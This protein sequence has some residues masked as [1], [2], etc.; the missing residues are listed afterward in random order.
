MDASWSPAAVSTLQRVE[1][2]AALAIKEPVGLLAE[3]KHSP[4]LSCVD[5]NV[6]VVPADVL[7]RKVG[8]EHGVQSSSPNV[9][10]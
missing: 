7:R 1:E 8:T 4:E 6:S 2:V 3:L 5:F 9:R 10:C